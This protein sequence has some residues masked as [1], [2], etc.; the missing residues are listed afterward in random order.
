MAFAMRIITLFSQETGCPVLGLGI[1]QFSEGRL[2][3]KITFG[4]LNPQV[5]ENFQYPAACIL[6]KTFISYPKRLDAAFGKVGFPSLLLD[7]NFPQTLHDLVVVID[8]TPFYGLIP[9]IAIGL[10]GFGKGDC[11]AEIILPFDVQKFERGGEQPG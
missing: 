9:K 6:N 11:L 10:N 4:E 5:L 3:R 1:C 8:R 7:T 2:R